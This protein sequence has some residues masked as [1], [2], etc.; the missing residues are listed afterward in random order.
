MKD[1][2]PSY[3]TVPDGCLVPPE[4]Q[5]EYFNLP[6]APAED[7]NLASALVDAHVARGR[8]DDVALIHH[9]SGDH[10]TY[11]Q[12]AAAST[13]FAN[14][15]E[16]LGVEPGHRVAFRF[17]NRPEALITALAA[18]RIGAIVVP[19]PMQARP[20]EIE[21][22]LQDTT[23]HVFVAWLDDTTSDDVGKAVGASDLPHLVA[24]GDEGGVPAHGWNELLGRSM[25]RRPQR[26]V[27]S[28]SPA[29]LWHTG[30]TTGQP[31][32]CYHTQRRFLQA[33]LSVGQA[34]GVRRGE[35]WAAAAP[36]GHALG[37]IY[38]TIFTL[39]HGAT[40][41]LIEGFARPEVTAL[42]LAAHRVDTFTAI[43]A[44]WSRLH[45][46]L[47]AEPEHDLSKLRRAYAMWQ[48]A[49][50]SDVRD[51]WSARGIELRNN[52]GS[53]AFAT[54]VLAPRPD[55][56]VTPASLG[57]PAP[58]YTV[59]VVDPDAAKP[60]PLAAGSVGRMAVRGP[61]GLTYWNRPSL[62]ERDVV[63][64]WTLV[65][66][67]IRFDAEGNAAYLGRTD[68]LISTAGYKVAPV[69][70]EAALAEHRSVREVAVVGIPDPMRQEI[71]AAAIS[72]KPGIE[73]GDGIR[74][75][76]QEF[77]RERLSPYKY[78][79]HIEF[80]DALPRDHV[81]KVQTR[82]LQERLSRQDKQ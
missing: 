64:G 26:G 41:V 78:P 38:H 80:V 16:A 75:E 9:E 46:A 43:A 37:F 45:E 22:F 79:R 36:L 8:G 63:D 21:F 42:A 33:G 17:P 53:T 73:P 74:R 48:S 47:L 67:L 71:V 81:G 35:R 57:R 70:V 1:V 51:D 76:L 56:R 55:E 18:W 31:K 28:D 40:V 15:L 66:D 12:L 14:G 29:I 23:P 54:W 11:R 6:D 25:D 3:P 24:V 2:Y 13:R 20:S 7:A 39:L 62:Q 61:T 59:D 34:T 30:G 77:V 82:V 32:G 58:G 44:T 60:Q 19:V 5:P 50:S 52:F 4:L 10:L 27:S 68:F 49:S 69:E 65:D 72:L